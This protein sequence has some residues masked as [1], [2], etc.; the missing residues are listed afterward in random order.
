MYQKLE[1]LLITRDQLENDT[2]E[3]LKFYGSDFAIDA[4][5]AQL[6]L[7]HTNYPLEGNIS[8]HDIIKIVKDMSAAEKAI[9]VEV[10]KLVRLLLVI[11]ATN[12]ISERLFSAMRRIKT[13]LQCCKSV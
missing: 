3:V 11:P 9:F 6:H 7:L 10:L 4:L 5:L 12:A 13:Y 2:D 1:Q 8:V